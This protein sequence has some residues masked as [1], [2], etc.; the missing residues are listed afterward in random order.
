MSGAARSTWTAARVPAQPALEIVTPAGTARDIG[1]QFELRVAGSALR[2]RV[3]EGSVSIDR[4]GR[5]LTGGAGEQ[6]AI[7]AQGGISRDA[8]EPDA[9]RMAMGR[10]HRADAGHG[11]QARCRADR[12]GC[13]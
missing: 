13:A 5:S 4:G 12:M 3:R 1:T 7:D 8:I 9:S 11:R 10:I 6:I 2:L